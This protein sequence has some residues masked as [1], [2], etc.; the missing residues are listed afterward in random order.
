MLGPYVIQSADVDRLLDR[1]GDSNRWQPDCGGEAGNVAIMPSEESLAP[2]ARPQRS[3][4]LH[5][6]RA[7]VPGARI[8]FNPMTGLGVSLLTAAGGEVFDLVDGQR[9]VADIARQ[10]AQEHGHAAT[11]VAAALAQLLAARLIHLGTAPPLPVHQPPRQLGVWL[12]VTNQCN[13][14]CTYCY[15]SK[16]NEAMPLPL[17]Q[18]ALRSVFDS[19]HGQGMHDLTLKYAGGEAL[20]EAE[21]IWALDAYARRLAADTIRVKSIILTNGTPLQPALIGELQARDF[22]LAISL[23]GLGAA[24]DN[25]RPLRG[26]QPSFRQVQAGIERAV[27]AGLTVSI[28]VVV[29]PGNLAALPELIDY[30]LD[31]D[32]RFSLT[33]LRD[34]SE[35]TVGLAAQDRSLI[36]G[37]EAAYARIAARPPRFSLMNAALDRVQLEQPHFAACGIGESYIVIKHTGEIASCQMRLGQPVG[38]VRRGDLLAQIA[39]RTPERP[40][41]TTVDDHQDCRSCDWRYRCAGGCP[42]VTFSA[43]GRF[44]Q[45]S[46]FC[47]VYKTLIPQLVAL[48]GLRL[49]RYGCFVQPSGI[50]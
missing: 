40:H 16:T 15:V 28:S 36:A 21:T 32:L 17:G 2:V 25:Q 31:R 44:D 43:H 42:V 39:A 37:M 14:R 10:V 8:V 48:E 19:M 9:T 11:G 30:L 49:A 27:A 35:A 6:D 23:D 18:R 5:E 50:V 1:L 29:G 41:G 34:S 13:L 20:L 46:P 12:H 26:G 38:H 33:F 47:G 7:T 4:L 24:H 45:A 22:Q 3:P